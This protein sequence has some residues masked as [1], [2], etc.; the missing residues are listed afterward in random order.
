MP[1][2]DKLKQLREENNVTQIEL[3]Q[4]IGVTDRNIRRYE[5]GIVE[6][7]L[8]VIVAIAK[9]FNTDTNYLLGISDVRE[10]RA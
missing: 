10:R 8:S 2:P 3:A 7:T 6:P 1:F 9:Y 4:A 5:K